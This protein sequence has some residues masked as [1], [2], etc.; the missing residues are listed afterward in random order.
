LDAN[1]VIAVEDTETNQ[2]AALQEQI[3]CYLFAGEY[4][5]TTYHLNA[6]SSLEILARQI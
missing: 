1:E 5:T 2:A 3:L 4:A 6:I